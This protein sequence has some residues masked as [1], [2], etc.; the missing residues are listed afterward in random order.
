MTYISEAK[1][2]VWAISQELETAGAKMSRR[3]LATKVYN[4]LADMEGCGGGID[5][6]E[7][8]EILER[9]TEYL[10]GGREALA[11]RDAKDPLWDGLES[12][13]EPLVTHVLHA[14]MYGKD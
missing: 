13:L 12:A 2:K 1:A 4:H 7:M 14:Q 11:M 3:D 6:D 10:A 8:L 9:V 5:P